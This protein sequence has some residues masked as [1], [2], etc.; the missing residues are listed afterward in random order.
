MDII[1]PILKQDKP[2]KKKREKN[3]DPKRQIIS[4]A[5]NKCF[6][7]PT[8]G[9]P[10]HYL[11]SQIIKCF[12]FFSNRRLKNT[13]NVDACAEIHFQ[14]KISDLSVSTQPKL[15]RFSSDSIF[16]LH[17]LNSIFKLRSSSSIFKLRSSNSIF[18]LHLDRTKLRKRESDRLEK[19]RQF[20]QPPSCLSKK[21]NTRK[22]VCFG[23]FYAPK[24]FF[25]INAAKSFFQN[26]AKVFYLILE[27]F[28]KCL[29][30]CRATF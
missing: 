11:V 28:N 15:A 22:C 14:I 9:Q 13:P 20:Y 26:E 16:K 4:A 2:R 18:K 6:Y 10:S 23:P 24:H 17:S 27:F 21:I 29:Q 25:K 30:L 12:A 3:L 5:T 1:Y 7:S 19:T 8:G